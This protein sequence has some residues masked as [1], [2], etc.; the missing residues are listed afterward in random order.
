MPSFCGLPGRLE[1]TAE[2]RNMLAQ[3]YLPITTAEGQNVLLT[4]SPRAV[5]GGVSFIF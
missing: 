2:F 3:G 4:H 5:R 1:A